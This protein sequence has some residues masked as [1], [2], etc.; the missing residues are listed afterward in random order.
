MVE[1]KENLIIEIVDLGEFHSDQLE[2]YFANLGVMHFDNQALYIP[3]ELSHKE[4]LELHDYVVGQNWYKFIYYVD[5]KTFLESGPH[6]LDQTSYDLDEFVE[7]NAELDLN[8]YNVYLDGLL[9]EH[10]IATNE[11]FEN[12]LGQ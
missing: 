9:P 4:K 8:N 1:A 10:I 12:Y 3:D 2:E 5:N 11:K 6:H 7:M